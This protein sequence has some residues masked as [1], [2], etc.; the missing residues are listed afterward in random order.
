MQTRVQRWG[1]S[2]ALRIPKAV[3]DD[4]GLSNN[5]QVELTVRKGK[6]VVAPASRPQLTDLVARITAEN[7]H[8]AEDC[9]MPVGREVW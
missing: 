6:L 7:L 1:N 8:A 3:A 2:L 4:L 5:G 9:G